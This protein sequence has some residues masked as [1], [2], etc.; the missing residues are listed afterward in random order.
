M[1]IRKKIVCFSASFA[2]I[3][4]TTCGFSRQESYPTASDSAAGAKL[5]FE[6]EFDGSVLD[7]SKWERCPEIE[8]CEGADVWDNA[9]SYPDGNGKL[10]LKAE[11]NGEEERVHSGAVRTKNKFYSGLGYYEASIRFPRAYGIWGA[12]W[13]MVGD[14]TN[15]VNNS[16]E[17]GIEIDIIES[18]DN[19][20]GSWNHAIYWDGYKD[21]QKKD[22][23]TNTYLNIY[24]GDFHTFGM[25]R[26]ED[27]YI[28][29]V[30]GRET[31]RSKGGGVCPLDGYMLL[32]VE[33]AAW[34]GSGTEKSIKALPAQME[35]DYVRVWDTNPYFKSGAAP[36]ESGGEEHDDRDMTV[37]LQ[38]DNPVMTVNGVKKQIDL[39]GTA[40]VLVNDRTL[41]PV[42]AVIEELGGDVGWDDGTQTAT[43]T[44]G[45]DTL[46]LQIDSVAAYLN[47]NP[48]TLDT[49][50]ILLGERT[51]LPIRFIAESF[52]FDVGWDNET[53]TVIIEKHAKRSADVNKFSFATQA[54]DINTSHNARQLGGYVCADG[55]K[56]K[57]N[58]LLRSGLLSWLSDEDIGV[59]ADKY[60]LKYIVDFR[61][62]EEMKSAPDK[63]IPGAK[64]YSFKVYGKD[65]Y[66][67]ETAAK[68]DDITPPDGDSVKQAL[69]FAE[70]G[71]IT[72][73]YERILLSEYAQEAYSKFF[74]VL[75][76]AKEGE[77]V[78]WHCSA[79]KDRTGVASALLLFALGADEAMV[80]RD[81]EITNEAYKEKLDAMAEV[82]CEKNLDEATTAEFLTAAVGADARYIKLA[83]KS[84]KEKYGSMDNYLRKELGLSDADKQALRDKFLQ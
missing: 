32:T 6:D 8:R 42:R 70:N 15:P 80:T 34:A 60:N 22:T 82:A 21:D 58:V 55:R 18:I 81:F 10:I 7:D 35:V 47:K 69:A 61:S 11:W 2:V 65:L 67:A 49:A 1:N 41:L 29:Y 44:Y 78:L 37:E 63:E 56:V 43:L 5:L 84:V 46:E 53:Q 51:M 39:E 62:D 20:N 72:E 4:T 54:L 27:G 24:D 59:L 38:I 19:G 12:F 73:R 14:S 40:P 48:Y 71:I 31:W 52:N 33:S 45:G 23:K 9:L 74:D 66:S 75:L 30:D 13:T 77:A 83:V 16:S 25:W 17:D 28:F 3:F 36:N 57:E 76:E 64:Y 26:A 68:L 79:G 50:P